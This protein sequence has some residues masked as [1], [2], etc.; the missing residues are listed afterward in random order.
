M[1][2]MFTFFSLF[3][4]SGGLDL[5]FKELGFK[6]L[7]ASDI[8]DES[9]KTFLCNWPTEP[10]IKKDIR[11]LSAQDI[12]GVT[13]GIKPDILLGG[14]PCQGFSVMGDKN[15]SDPRNT[16]FESYVRL[17]SDLQ[18]YCFVFENVKG[19]KTMFNGLYFKKVVN[20]F[21]SIGY[22]IYVKILNAADYGVPQKRERVV[23]IGTRRKNAYQYPAGSNSR[24]GKIK[25]FK[26]VKEAIM[27]LEPK[28]SEIPNHIA[29]DHGS[30]V[31]A[32]YKLIPEGGGLPSPELLPIEIRRKSFG[33]T[34]TRLH[35]ERVSPTMVPGN[36]AF[37]IH[38][39][40]DR[41]LTP[42]EAARIQTFPDNVVFSGTRRHQCILVG[43]AVPV[44]LGAH[45]AKSIKLHLENKSTPDKQDLLLGRYEQLNIDNKKTSKSSK[46]QKLTFI[47]L[48]SGAGGITIGLMNAGMEPLLS[49]DN[50]PSV[51]KTHRHNFPEV[52]FVEGDLSDRRTEKKILDIIGK[53]EVDLIVGGPPC[54][55][56]SIFGERRFLNTQ[57]RE[58]N[59]HNDPRNKLVY[60]YINYVKKINPKWF[61][62]EN[63]PGFASLDDGY[64][65][66]NLISEL[67][68]NGYKNLDWK[69]INTADYG[70]PQRRKRFIMI[71]NRTGNIVPWPKPKFFAKPEDWQ[72]PYRT[73][74]EV[75]SELSEKR[76]YKIFK[77]HEP[78]NHSAHLVERFSFIE[79]GQKMDLNKIPEHLKIGVHTG[80]KIKN[81]SH[82]YKRLDMNKPSTTLVPGHSAFPIHPK[83]NRTLTVREGAR[84]QTF[85]DYIEF[86]GSRSS[87]Y[88]QV[89]N[90]FPAVAAESIG[91][92]IIKTI[93]NDWKEENVS[94]LAQYSLID[95]E[96][97]KSKVIKYAS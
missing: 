25:A 16:L 5:G 57:N 21:A 9:E 59:P 48:F 42:R 32:R 63:V 8:M 49:S 72:K 39:T 50:D 93:V 88:K 18:P 82:V 12:L 43:N 10:F 96:N 56:F 71:G 2:K 29:L 79:E 76:S 6:S 20:S 51:A 55:G 15:S 23:I 66:K 58:Y 78:M 69:I 85:P 53:K 52:P 95:V 27:D 35:R 30:K 17:V 45:I 24:I 19:F 64:F 1:S 70:V 94:G 28:G 54:Q 46:Q 77:N 26:N 4:G 40:L 83:L 81:Y 89:G 90:A 62:M 22:D 97:K 92:M 34:Y 38:P 60:T 68:K 80:Q 44:L 61:I 91:N 87:Q 13:R 75:I 33:N 67:K 31:L 7:G 74:G 14:P 47:D 86:L 84:I 65:L 37:P 11:Q 36:N 3:S 41:S 73:V